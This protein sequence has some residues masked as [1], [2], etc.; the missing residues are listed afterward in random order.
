MLTRLLGLI[1]NRWT[2]LALLLLALMGVIWIIGPLIAIGEARPLDSERARWIAIG[3]VL[4]VTALLIGW[5]RWSARRGNAQVVQQLVAAPPG[6]AA[7]SADMAA[8]R[9]RFTGALQVLRNARF[10]A[11]AGTGFWHQL[12]QRLGGR[13]LYQMPWY[14]IIGAPGTGKTTALRNAGLQFP[15][16][17]RM[18]EQAVR[19]VGGTRNCDWWFTDR[20]VLI[21][22]AGRFT[23]QDSDQA[24][25]KATWSGFLNLLK[26]SRPRQ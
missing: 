15:L 25:D 21:D 12:G 10:G 2:L 14:M 23:T 11:A 6:K 9:E 3:I 17:A 13:Y 22:T 4:L 5:G 24:T 20:A 16:A 18:G 19:G 26:R 1:F 7:E 8:V